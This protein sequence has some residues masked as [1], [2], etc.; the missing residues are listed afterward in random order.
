MPKIPSLAWSALALLVA[1]LAGAGATALAWHTAAAKDQATRT[2]WQDSTSKSFAL[3]TL[4][5]A[6]H[7][8][9]LEREAA[10]LAASRDA[11]LAA[12]NRAKTASLESLKKLD[13]L[14]AA[15]AAAPDIAAL[16]VAQT[17]MIGEQDTVIREQAHEIRALRESIGAA[18]EHGALL[19]L[20]IDSL[21]GTIR[22]RDIRIAALDSAVAA[23]GTPALPRGKLFGFLPRLYCGPGVAFGTD[24]KARPAIACVKPL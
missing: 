8:A 10:V 4:A 16:V 12:A 17:A 18:I 9:Q 7:V 14:R 5:R 11:G 1:F 13:A 3:D 22:G 24:A 15:V 23:R 6:Q 2:H 20:V 19:Q 21:G